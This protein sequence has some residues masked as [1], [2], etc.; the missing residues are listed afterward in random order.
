LIRNWSINSDKRLNYHC[1]ACD[2]S[3]FSV[4]LFLFV[5]IIY[6]FKNNNNNNNNNNNTVNNNNYSFIAVVEAKQKDGESI[7]SVEDCE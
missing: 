4:N 2:L 1:L 3:V 7:D 5:I 6:K